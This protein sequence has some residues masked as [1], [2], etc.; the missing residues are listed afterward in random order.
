MSLNAQSRDQHPGSPSGIDPTCVSFI[1]RIFLVPDE[2]SEHS[3]TL[4]TSIIADDDRLYFVSKNKRANQTQ[5]WGRRERVEGWGDPRNSVYKRVN[6]GPFSR[7]R[8]SWSHRRISSRIHR[9]EIWAHL[10]DTIKN[11]RL[12]PAAVT[13]ELL[14]NRLENGLIKPV[15]QST[16]HWPS[17]GVSPDRR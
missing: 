12:E 4:L 10:S 1:N 2:R 13:F 15:M 11:T 17:P 5:D 8:W 14:R 9:V 16:E 6:F 3:P 7:T